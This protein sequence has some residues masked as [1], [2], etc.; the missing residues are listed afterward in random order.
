MLST[1]PGAKAT[2]EIGDASLRAKSGDIS[3][4]AFLVRE[5]GV[6]VSMTCGSAQC[7]EPGQI[8]KIA[9][10]VESRLSE[11]PAEPPRAPPPRRRPAPR[12]H[13][14]PTTRR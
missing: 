7:T 5:R 11:L 13:P 6:V 8:A 3:G 4:L 2:D 1:L 9:K 10:L 12:Q 14:I